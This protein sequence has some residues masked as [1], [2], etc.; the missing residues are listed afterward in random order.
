MLT[1]VLETIVKGSTIEFLNIPE[2]EFI[3]NYENIDKEAAKKCTEDY[4]NSKNIDV[5]S[6]IMEIKLYKDTH[7]VQITLD[8]KK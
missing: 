1:N 4:F 7:N 6:N 8:R 3:A 2:N 5:K